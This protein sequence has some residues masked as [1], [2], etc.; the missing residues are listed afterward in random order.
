V[1]RGEKVELHV[2]P[3]QALDHPPA[4]A[5]SQA[6][7]DLLGDDHLP[8]GTYRV[9]HGITSSLQ[10][11][12]NR[13]RFPAVGAAVGV[14]KG[15]IAPGGGGGEGAGIRSDPRPL[16]GLLDGRGGAPVAEGAAPAA[17]ARDPPPLQQGLHAPGQPSAERLG[18]GA[19]GDGH[20]PEGVPG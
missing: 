13:S 12:P 2:V 4:G 15:R 19:A 9:G 16:R 5:D 8:L 17:G 11:N 10:Y 20:L 14:P 3:H 7:P 1:G 18:L 6:L